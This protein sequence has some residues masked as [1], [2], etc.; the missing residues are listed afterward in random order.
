MSN[1]KDT[2]SALKDTRLDTS[3]KS[4]G[5]GNFGR[6]KIEDNELSQASFESKQSCVALNKDQ[7]IDEHQ[8]FRYFTSP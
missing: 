2:T 1:R 6:E 3:I 4:A 8:Q 7:S 5:R